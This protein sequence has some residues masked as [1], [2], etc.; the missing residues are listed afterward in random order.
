MRSGR[1]G[2]AGGSEE[3]GTE[4]EEAPVLST[5]LIQTSLP[6]FHDSSVWCSY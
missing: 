5:T 1:E 4:G 3:R 2:R 6:F